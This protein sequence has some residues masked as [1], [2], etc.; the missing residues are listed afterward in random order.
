MGL[1]LFYGAFL[2]LSYD[3]GSGWNIG[4]IPRWA[5]KDYADDYEIVGEQREDLFFFVRAMDNAYRKYLEDKTEKNR[6]INNRRKK[7]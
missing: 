5:I 6:K 4:P 1:E 3:R 7:K 2:D